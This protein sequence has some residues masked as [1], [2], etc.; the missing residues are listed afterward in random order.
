MYHHPEMDSTQCFKR[1][2]L[3]AESLLIY[4]S[5]NVKLVG[6]NKQNETRRPNYEGYENVR[7][8]F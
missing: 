1:E 7:Y 4:L 5:D 6:P 8:G 2:V 3:P